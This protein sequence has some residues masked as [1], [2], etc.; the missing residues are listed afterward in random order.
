MPR[1]KPPSPLKPR[2][3]RMSDEEWA[4]FKELGGAEWL[5]RFMGS[6]PD[7]YYKVFKRHDDHDDPSRD[8]VA[9]RSSAG[10]T[11]GANAP[12]SKDREPND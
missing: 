11:P 6:R 4:K 12:V 5:R 8:V 9:V 2:P 7:G 1:P 3:V 10:K